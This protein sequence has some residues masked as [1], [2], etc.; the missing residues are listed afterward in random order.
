[1]RKS[2]IADYYDELERGKAFGMLYLTGAI[3]AMLGTLY[4][5]N[6][7]E[8]PDEV[9]RCAGSQG[10]LAGLG[11]VLFCFA[12]SVLRLFEVIACISL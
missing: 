10:A 9:C 3:G 1:M 6:V 12:Y 8:L 5:T 11:P 7:G 2:L 4:G